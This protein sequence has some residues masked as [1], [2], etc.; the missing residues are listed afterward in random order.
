MH[1]NL[2]CQKSFF[3]NKLCQIYIELSAQELMANYVCGTSELKKI[4]LMLKIVIL[5]WIIN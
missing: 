5:F 2:L 4:R 1:I 3:N